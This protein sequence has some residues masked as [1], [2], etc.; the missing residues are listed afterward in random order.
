MALTKKREEST[1]PTL[2][3]WEDVDNLAAH[4]T[5]KARLEVPKE[6]REF[7]QEHDWNY[8]WIN[9]KA[10]VDQ[11]GRHQHH[12]KPLNLDAANIQVS[13]MAWGKRPDGFL[14][15]GDLVLAV[16]PQKL[17]TAHKA[18]LQRRSDRLLKAAG[19]YGSDELK[20]IM[21]EAGVKGKVHEGYED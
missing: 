4:F 12:W 8:R 19:S 5:K 10:F 18:D 2:P 7:C 17:T 1:K 9:N 3:A 13:T 16:R 21:R 11:G 20:R 6:I 15:Y 14:Y